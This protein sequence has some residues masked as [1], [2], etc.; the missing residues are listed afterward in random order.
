MGPGYNEVDRPKIVVA[1]MNRLGDER[2]LYN[3][4]I[5]HQQ[6]F[7]CSECGAPGKDSTL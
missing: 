4:Q 2:I 7:C 6:C 5:Y 3:N 1:K